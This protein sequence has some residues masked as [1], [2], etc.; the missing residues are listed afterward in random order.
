VRGWAAWLVLAL[1]LPAA[2][3]AEA[4]TVF[5]AVT[6][7]GYNTGL[8]VSFDQ[9]DDKLLATV[10][11]LGHIGLVV[12]EA[13]SKQPDKL[14]DLSS[15]PGVHFVFHTDQQTLDIQADEAALRRNIIGHQ[16]S[17]DLPDKAA[18]GVLFNYGVAFSA[19]TTGGS[20][21][22]GN[23]EF[24]G[25]GPPGILDS[26]WYYGP[27]EN[28]S[29]DFRRLDT[30]FIHDDAESL[31]TWTAGD[32]ISAS[33]PWTRPVRGV[34]FSLATDFAIR[35]D[36]ITQPMPWLQGTA[37]VPSTVD[38]YLNGVH[39]LSQTTPPGPF[40][41]TQVPVV[42]GEGQ[43]SLTVSD[44]LGRQTVQ[45][46]SFYA[47]D[48]LL[49]PGLMSYALEGGWLRENFGQLDDHYTDPFAQAMVSRGMNDWLTLEGR[50]AGT[51]GVVEIG[52]G[53]VAKLAEFAVVNLSLDDSSLSG[54]DGR[55]VRAS[56]ERQAGPYFLFASAQQSFGDFRD[57]ASAAGD[58]PIQSGFQ[59][60]A[61]WNSASLGTFGLDYFQQKTEQGDFHLSEDHPSFDNIGIVTA[62]W[63][64]PFAKGWTAYASAYR[65]VVGTSSFGFMVGVSISPGDGLIVDGGVGQSGKRIGAFADASQSPPTDGGWGWSAQA[66][67]APE[68]S[69]QGSV[70]Y[71]SHI[72]EV[73]AGVLASSAGT[74]GSAYA[75]GSVVWLAGG[76][77]RLARQSGAS[78]AEVDTGEPGVG[79]TLEN[80]DMGKTGSDGRLLVPDLISFTPNHFAI[81]PDTV[82]LSNEIVTSSAVVRPPRNA[83][84]IVE[85]PVHP[86]RSAAVRFVMADGTPV[87]FNSPVTLNGQ[88]AGNVGYDGVAW[89]G[90]L[91]DD[92]RVRIGE[93]DQAC[94]AEFPFAT[95]AFKPGVQIGPFV[96]K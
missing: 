71:I 9:Q 75:T 53:L 50:L 65:S 47:T 48:Q 5:A 36:L 24:R 91:T 77:P 56:I 62:S 21:T 43:V 16:P 45:S 69:G 30:A 49:A 17:T 38:L 83:G 90:P 12:P 60:G 67:S 84:V 55:Q 82:P 58:A 46:F 87:T 40:S 20:E 74:L 11:D 52:A 79:V 33:L 27:M 63:S 29:T 37:S 4:A 19:A 15:L 32:F 73:G 22:S 88:D 78:F 7:N 14:I 2:Q 64:Y 72:G 26:N 6:V 93:G 41:V 95:Q 34:G 54:R 28:G 1:I 85:L 42:N 68:P 13:A 66:Q 94:T 39:Q 61:G 10:D 80:R 76:N 8:I 96:C 59:A 3:K 81:E 35:P 92:N 86:S 51:S 89:L 31:Q 18:W 70:R 23:V 57:V 44:A 25:F